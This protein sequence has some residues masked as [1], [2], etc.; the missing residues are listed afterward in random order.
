MPDTF[1]SRRAV[2]AGLCAAPL[3]AQRPKP[4]P[5]VLFLAVD[6]LNTSLACYGAKMVAS[7]NIDGIAKRGVRFDKA[8]CQY[9]LCN[10]SRSSL[11]TGR[12][13]PRTKVV[14]NAVWFRDTMPEA[15][16]L[17]QFFRENGYTTAVTGKIFHGGLDDDKGWEIGGTQLRRQAP[18][19]GRA[20]AEREKHAD[21]WVALD[22]DGE[23]E[24][25]YHTATRAVEL[26]EQ[27][28]DK[29]FFLAV[30]FARPH[31]PFIAPKKY[32]DLY[33]PKR[34]ELPP[35]FAS[36][37]AGTTPAFRP[38]FD[39]FIR[40]EASPD[41]ARQAIAAYYASISF[42]DAQLG[43]VLSALDRLGLRENTIISLFG[44]HGWHLGEKGMW[45]K[46]SLFEA[47]VR[48]PLM[49]STPGMKSAG[50]TC[51]RPV[52]FI[53][54]YPTLADLCGL[55]APK[56]VEGKSIAPLL[57]NPA[58]AWNRPAYTFIQRATVKGATV[59]TERFR[60]TEWD[61]GAQGT[62]LYDEPNDAAEMRNVAADPKYAAHAARDSY[63]TTCRILASSSVKGT[64]PG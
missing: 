8:Y 25:D 18:R 50:K 38:N 58:A 39:L 5:N 17:P 40:R 4:R 51:A 48:A 41:Q 22:N 45:S 57:K 32:F 26:L 56:G 1:I 47:S 2:L 29:P 12:R 64:A 14:N 59:R 54:M 53:D 11:L 7:P 44:D 21:R 52:E 63:C 23:G 42:M 55:P 43:R 13:P 36:M 30:G 9:P 35:D 31:V 49:F 15:V 16:T 61:G 6:D 62:E 60:Y 3:A 19:A 46:Q 20:Q 10:P 24:I 34:I 27:K 28:R 33:D 37:P